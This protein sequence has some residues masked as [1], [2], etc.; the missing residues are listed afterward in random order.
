MHRFMNDDS[1]ILNVMASEGN[2]PVS[3]WDRDLASGKRN[4]PGLVEGILNF[5]LANEIMIDSLYKFDDNFVKGSFTMVSTHPGMLKTDLHR[6]QG[7]A[8]D[9]IEGVMVALLGVSEE[10]AGVRQTSNLVA[11]KLHKNELS[12]VDQ[13]GFGRLRDDVSIS[14]VDDNSEWL[15]SFLTT[16]ES[17]SSTCKSEQ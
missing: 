15:W 4:V 16:L 10:T 13:F 8:F 6:G 11:A 3:M 14:F 2:L 9:I 7:L 17:K 1:R 12:F 5:A